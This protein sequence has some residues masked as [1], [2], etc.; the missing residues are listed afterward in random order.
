MPNYA[1]FYVAGLWIRINFFADPDPA[2][3]RNADP[4]PPV[5]LMRILTRIQ[6]KTNSKK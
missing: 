4:D 5:F 6:L 2:N 3:F 1:L